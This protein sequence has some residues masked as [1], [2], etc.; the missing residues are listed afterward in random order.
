MFEV[1]GNNAQFIVQKVY[2][3]DV[4]IWMSTKTNEVDM[5]QH[6]IWSKVEELYSTI[7]F[8]NTI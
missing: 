3:N 2:Y 1:L 5:D 4:N 6:D 8:I 7:L